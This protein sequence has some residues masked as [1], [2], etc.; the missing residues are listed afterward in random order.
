MTCTSRHRWPPLI[1]NSSV[2]T[3]IIMAIAEYGA[4]T[5]K[6]LCTLFDLPRPH[7]NKRLLELQST[8]LLV[9]FRWGGPTNV[10]GRR[11]RRHGARK[12]MWTIDPRHPLFRRLL[13]LGRRLAIDFPL[14]GPGPVKSP[15][16]VTQL[17]RIPKLM[18]S[19]SELQVFGDK[20]MARVIMLLSR[21]S[22]LSV[23]PLRRLL[24][25]S[26]GTI[27]AIDSLAQIGILTIQ[28]RRKGQPGFVTLNPKLY[29]YGH[30]R[31]LAQFID[32]TSGKEYLVLAQAAGIQIYRKR[33]N[34]INAG[35][36]TRQARGR[37]YFL[38]PTG[39]AVTGWW[40][41]WTPPKRI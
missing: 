36:A 33:L 40:N 5:L 38:K 37:P 12:L 19:V 14:C 11:K 16:R 34:K 28:P 13:L 3:A 8:K 31:K 26:K 24:G 29:A 20:P 23:Y 2:Q 27:N 7:L 10:K 21:I 4:V 30:L 22:K 15:R 18:L 1:H 17:P 6:D 39:F 25:L 35:R 41:R 32:K 9:S